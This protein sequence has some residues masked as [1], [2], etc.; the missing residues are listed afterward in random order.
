MRRNSEPSRHVCDLVDMRD[1]YRCVR[2]GHLFHWAGFSRHHRHLR[3]HPYP[4]LH[5]PSNLIL[6]CG[7]GA[8]ENGC[9]QWVH[10]HRSEAETFGWIV[11]GFDEHPELVPVLTRQH[12]WVLLD[13]GGGWTAWTSSNG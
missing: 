13:D 8:S 7:S 12:G 3:S 5:E 10:E 6:L 9:H 11:S 2:C 1:E 4:R